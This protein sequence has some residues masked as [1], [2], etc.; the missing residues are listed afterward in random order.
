MFLPSV[1]SVADEAIGNEKA[2]QTED[3]LEAIKRAL[4]T[5]NAP[6]AK[7]NEAN[8]ATEAN[9]AGNE[10]ECLLVVNKAEIKTEEHR[11]ASR[12]LRAEAAAPVELVSNYDWI[13][14]NDT[15]G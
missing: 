15:I 9:E 7:T 10:V 2:I 13:L 14:K 5:S 11:P 3:N 8:K 12:T 4:K 1:V 6:I